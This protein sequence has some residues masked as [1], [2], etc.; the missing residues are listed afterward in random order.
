MAKV[1][2]GK[3]TATRID[4]DRVGPV[5]R[6]RHRRVATHDDLFPRCFCRFQMS[7]LPEAY[8][9]IILLHILG[10]GQVGSDSGVDERI[11]FTMLRRLLP[12]ILPAGIPYQPDHG[13]FFSG[14]LPFAGPGAQHPGYH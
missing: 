12:L 3:E 6:F 4:V 11:I 1:R 2:V 7:T 10:H 13:H 8:H 14:G 5:D 9:G